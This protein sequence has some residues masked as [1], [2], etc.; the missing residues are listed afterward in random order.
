MDPTAR[1]LKALADGTYHAIVHMTEDTFEPPGTAKS[2]VP[3]FLRTL[4]E[5][6]GLTREALI[7]HDAVDALWQR[8]LREVALELL[9]TVA[10]SA[11]TDECVID[12]PVMTKVYGR[13]NV[14]GLSRR[15]G[16]DAAYAEAAVQSM[17][18]L[19]IEA[20]QAAGTVEISIEDHAL[21]LLAA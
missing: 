13:I 21:R 7:T 4:A 2:E 9:R 5:A 8:H 18:R 14:S 16:M 20:V 17:A 1:F 6:G 10:S 19:L 3:L 12:D 11:S 15:T